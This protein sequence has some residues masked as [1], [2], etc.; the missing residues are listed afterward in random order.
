MT[1]SKNEL[2]IA[3]KLMENPH[4]NIV[5]IYDVGTDYIDMENVDIFVYEISNDTILQ[6]KQVM[7]KVKDFLQENGIIYIDWKIDNIGISQDG[8]FKL[9]DFDCSGMIDTNDKTKWT[10]EPLHA[11][12]YINAI[13]NGM[14]TPI[15]IDNYSFESEFNSELGL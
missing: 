4:E 13:K 15:E 5:R 12:S 1:R 2:A 6:I 7:N 8:K 11:F 14:K 10:M 9:F 3:R